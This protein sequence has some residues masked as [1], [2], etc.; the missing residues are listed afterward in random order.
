MSDFGTELGNSGMNVMGKLVDALLKLIEKIYE[1]FKEKT[2]VD[3]KLKKAE[4]REMKDKAAKRKF[5][6]KIEGKTGYVKHKD[7]VK[8]GVPLTVCGISVDDKGFKELAERCKREGIVITG[9]E[10]I[11]QRDLTGKKFF[12]VECRQSD[13]ERLK[14]L[15]DLMNDE[16]RI[17]NVQ[18]DIEKIEVENEELKG[19]LA[20]LKEKEEPTQEEL[21]RIKEIEDKIESNNLVID[22]LNKRIEDIRYGHSEELNQEQAQGVVEQ[23]VNGETLR[24]VT[25][26][27]AVDRWTGGSID[28]D[29]TCYVVDAKDP[30]RYIICTAR[31][32]TF[33][34]QEYIKTTY[35]VYN[36]SK[37]VYATND[38][39]FE[40]RPKDYWFREKAAM[41]DKGG[42]GDLV[43]KFYSVKE[44]EAYRQN[45]KAQNA[46][47]LD[48]LDVG[49]EGRDYDAIIKTLEAKIDECGGVYKDGVVFNKES[50]KTITLTESMS[51]VDKANA[52]EAVVVG[53]QIDNYKEIKQLESEVAIA[54]TNVLVASEGTEEHTV[55]KAE[56][57]K[58]ES[59]YKAALNTESQ[60]IEERK[61][62]N[63]VQAEQDVKTS[64]VKDIEY[65][66]QDKA[67]ITDLETQIAD[68]EAYNLE[69]KQ[70]MFLNYSDNPTVYKEMAQELEQKEQEVISMRKELE[71]MK[72]QAVK[73]IQGAEKTDD[74][75]DER[76]SEVEDNR[77]TMAEYKGEIADRK[78]SDGAKG[79]DVRDRDITKQKNVPNIK[80]DR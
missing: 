28:K 55:A 66:P 43:I 36:G 12:Y 1:T 4:Y 11:R 29:T 62:I 31:N 20:V 79:N 35:E 33:R 22:G 17:K 24:G 60:L 9:V 75:R 59:K 73:N 19:E 16:Q 38:R 40:G 15:L 77:R 56:F 41:R 27:E 65:L 30:N 21:D 51:D 25:F 32:D 46:T 57:E 71:E 70:S 63:A 23:A 39:R 8:A 53:K 68:K 69:Y 7:L 64:S 76:V 45:Y 6:E 48:G 37:Q 14:D 78:N 13:A 47:E 61:S 67:A 26:D 49:K 3:Y 44:L 54:R 34:N 80:E 50:G 52:A 10:D 2:S 5:I 42:F 58:V 18:E 74:R 72:M